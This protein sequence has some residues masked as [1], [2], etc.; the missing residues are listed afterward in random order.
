MH[1][2][3]AHLLSGKIK[4]LDGFRGLAVFLLCCYHFL[5]FFSFAFASV[6]LFF[7]LSG[8]LITG[9]LVEA[10]GSKNYFRNFYIN[11][12]LRIVPLC[13]TVLLIFFVLIPVL[14]PSFVSASFKELLQQQVY[15][16]T[17]TANIQDAL[18]GWPLN[19]TLIHFWS[20]AC[21]MQ[22]YLVWP[23]VIYFF[24]KKKGSLVIILVVFSLLSILF[25]VY[26]N[27]YW[28]L[29]FA[30]RHV[31][32]PSRLDSF[33]AGALLY[34]A[35]SGD[36]ITPYKKAFGFI[37]AFVPCIVL[38]IMAVIK[39]PWHFGVEFV[40]K[41]GYTLNVIFWFALVAFALTPGSNFCERL[42]SGRVM[43]SLGK[44]SYGIYVFHLP[45]YIII[46]K[47]NLFNTGPEDKT[48][49]LAVVAFAV[50]CVCG[51]ASFHL[52]E[53]HFLKLKPVK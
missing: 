29:R 14:L 45:V 22:F 40:S 46:A 32:L 42:L 18:Q 38:L 51:F 30:Y 17:F 12:I 11:R 44:Y 13:F 8:F 36:K 28:H 27:D 34:L 37:I 39:A 24:Y 31:L 2:Q 26:A 6:D 43:T 19:I 21:E 5:H 53:K 20:L 10:L 4:V 48:L 41:Y 16:W 52:L 1:P 15:Y 49:L 23:F 9:K 35:F 7:V 3:S 33:C 25:R 47:K 50:S